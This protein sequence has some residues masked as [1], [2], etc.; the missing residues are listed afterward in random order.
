MGFWHVYQN[1]WMEKELVLSTNGAGPPDIHMQ[2]NEAAPLLQN[3]H[4]INSK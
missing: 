2:M 1:N 3:V 4:K